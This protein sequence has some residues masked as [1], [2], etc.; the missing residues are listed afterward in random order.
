[1]IFR[2]TLTVVRTASQNLGTHMTG[3][4]DV[5]EVGQ[6]RNRSKPWALQRPEGAGTVAIL[7]PNERGQLARVLV[8]QQMQQVDG[9][10]KIAAKSVEQ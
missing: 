3:P 5:D 10:P 6:G 4:H 8:A 7:G 2:R 1:M 9:L